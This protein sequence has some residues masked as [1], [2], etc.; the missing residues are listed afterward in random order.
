MA[1]LACVTLGALA[2]TAGAARQTHGT[3][4]PTLV[5]LKG[6]VKSA[7]S[8]N[9]FPSSQAPRLTPNLI[10]ASYQGPCM[11]DKTAGPA[12]NTSCD[13]GL[14]SSSKVVVLYG[15][16][17]AAMWQPAFNWL[18]VTDKFRLVLVTRRNC[19]FASLKSSDYMDPNCAAWKS[20][21]VS[22]INS[23]N[24]SIV[25]FAEKNVGDID[26]GAPTDSPSVFAADVK[27][28]MKAVGGA[29]A[30]R[31][32]LTGMPYFDAVPK[33]GTDPGP[34]MAANLSTLK[35]CSTPL[36]QA[37]SAD[38]QRADKAAAKSAGAT[39]VS[40]QPLFCGPSTCPV[41]IGG[42]IAWSNQFHTPIWYAAFVRVALRQLVKPA[43]L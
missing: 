11:I 7:Q 40:V 10:H 29:G 31:V 21:A 18:G 33:G 43:G 42:M 2:P 15:D 9:K 34:C 37:F 17:T 12:L 25:V 27:T 41:V 5:R 3:P 6:L 22:Y 4:A 23:L 36:N 26:P 39:T 13:F 1:V 30:K 8:L 38:R 20:N 35:T 19:P 24:P 16:S 14:K 28:A 32:F